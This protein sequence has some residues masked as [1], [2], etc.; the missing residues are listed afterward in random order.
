MTRRLEAAA[1][2]VHPAR[3]VEWDRNPRKIT[4]DAVQ[5]LAAAIDRFGFG[6]PIVA[7]RGSGRVIAGHTRLR[8]AQHLGLE[9]V[10]VR[11]MDLSDEDAA[12][13]ALADNKLGELVEWDDV[14]LDALLAELGEQGWDL[15]LLGFDAPEADPPEAPEPQ[16]VHEGPATSRPGE[17]Y[18]LGPH[19]LVCGD[20]SDPAT[21]AALDA[22][23]GDRGYDITWTDPPYGVAYESRNHGDTY[24]TNARASGKV[25]APIAN[26]D[27]TVEELAE[28]LRRVFVPASERSRAGG[29]W[30]VAAPAGYQRHAFCLVLTEL[31][32]WRHE[33]IWRKDRLV[34]GR[35]D[36]HYQHEPI[37]YGWKDGGGHVWSGGRQRTSVIDCP[38]PSRSDDHPTMKP[39]ELVEECLGCHREDGKTELVLDPFGGSG[40]TLIAAARLGMQAHTIELSE[41]YCDVIRKRWGEYADRAGLDRGDAL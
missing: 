9:R 5:R 26:D 31:G 30:Y 18:R 8:A 23:R 29:V 35:A 36:R 32:L 7:Q 6:S 39:V 28:L 15:E 20:S 12:A 24:G 40:T 34:L 2:W 4:E 16:M 13:M 38:R 22:I 10:P 21:W 17:V 19:V 25:H 37:F 27:L 14:G 1:E 33:V 41:H 11:W 3:L